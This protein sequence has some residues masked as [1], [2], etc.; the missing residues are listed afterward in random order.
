MCGIV[1]AVAKRPIAKLLLNGLKRLEYRGYDSAGIAVLDVQQHLQRLRVLGKVNKLE[2]AMHEHPLDDAHVGIAHTRWA[3][4]GAPSEQNAH[5]FISNDQF[6]LVH[7]GIVE[8]HAVLRDKLIK[9][10]YQFLSETDTETVVH[11]IHYHFTQTNDFLKAVR[12]AVNELKGAFAFS[13]LSTQSP[14]R[15]IG[16]RQG[17]PLFWH[18]IRWLLYLKH[19]N[20]FI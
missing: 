8:N 3:T 11:L 18:P 20:L 1:G 19:S 6:A 15:L 13:I 7:N 14:N 17:A 16:V 12:L 9:L 5:P 10:G 4:H 2:H